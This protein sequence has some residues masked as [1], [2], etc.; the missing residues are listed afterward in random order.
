MRVL[1]DTEAWLWGLL[2]PDR[3]GT[4]AQ[5]L[6]EGQRYPLFLSAASSWEIA[7]KVGLGKLRLPEPAER[8]VPSRL[9]DQG[10]EALPIQHSHA[11][12]VASLPRH[13]SDP[14]DRLLVAQAQLERMAIL[15]ADPVFTSYGVQTIWAGH[16]E[17]PRSRSRPAP[18]TRARP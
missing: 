13:H 17:P 12:H 16:G 5:E 2:A 14:F 18:R 10:I 1:L 9:A 3:L 7:I 4:R 8:Y 15:S 11:L 6:I